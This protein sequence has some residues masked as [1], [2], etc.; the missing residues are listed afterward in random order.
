MDE[1]EDHRVNHTG[2]QNFDSL[3]D[4]LLREKETPLKHGQEKHG[5]VR[6]C[7]R[8][9][10]S[11]ESIP[12]DIDEVDEDSNG[13][14]EVQRKHKQH[15]RK[16]NRSLKEEKSL[17]CKKCTGKFQTKVDLANHQVDHIESDYTI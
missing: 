17:I 14:W 9:E 3:C 4:E 6:T 10:T 12:M 16:R 7:N 1:V 2:N 11:G 13:I 15:N 8:L 5:K